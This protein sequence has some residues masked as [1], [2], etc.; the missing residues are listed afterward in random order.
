MRN[1]GSGGIPTDSAVRAV[2]RQF[3]TETGQT[4]QPLP[5]PRGEPMLP[6]VFGQP[7]RAKSEFVKV[8]HG[9]WLPPLVEGPLGSGT[10]INKGMTINL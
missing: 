8:L 9:Y 3:E 2:L 1:A 7:M 6:Y 5:K 10:E 4:D